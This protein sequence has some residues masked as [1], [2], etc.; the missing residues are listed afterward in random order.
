VSLSADTSLES[1]PYR[2]ISPLAVVACILGAASALSLTHPLFWFLPPVTIIVSILALRS[3]AK[4]RDSLVG[5]KAALAGLAAA[6]FFGVWAPTSTTMQQV[7][8]PRHARPFANYWLDLLRDGRVQEAH[9]WTIMPD[10]RVPADFDLNEFY[11]S[12]T[13]AKEDLEVFL[14]DAVIRSLVRLGRAGKPHLVRTVAVEGTGKHSRTVLDYQVTSKDPSVEPFDVRIIIE[15]MLEP[16]DR[17][18]QWRVVETYSRALP[19]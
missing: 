15:R 16:S 3:V 1:E 18:V 6:T 7:L 8:I 11:E 5:R 10:Y 19:S 2:A 4:N 13:D 12:D 14:D 9:Q 17:S